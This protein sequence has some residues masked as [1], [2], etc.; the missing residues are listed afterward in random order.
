MFPRLFCP[1]VP[2][3]P[4]PPHRRI[5]NLRSRAPALADA[6]AGAVSTIVRDTCTMHKGYEVY[7]D[8]DA[9][10]LL[11]F[12]TP[13][14][15]L[16]W[17]V[18][19]EKA[20]AQASHHPDLKGEPDFRTNIVYGVRVFSGPRIQV[21]SVPHALARGSVVKLSFFFKIY[22]VSKLMKKYLLSFSSAGGFSTKYLTS[23]PTQ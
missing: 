11:A 10:F 12:H 17:H 8:S 22:S 1:R 16:Q 19:L 15:A 7:A 18:A 9:S 5:A 14:A 6:V 20:A 13:V 3:P 4:P 21:R 23:V 2:P